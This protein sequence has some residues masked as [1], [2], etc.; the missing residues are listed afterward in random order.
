MRLLRT[1]IYL[2]LTAAV[3]LTFGVGL[4]FLPQTFMEALAIAMSEQAHMFLRFL[5]ASLI[6]HAYLNWQVR[7]AE[8]RIVGPVLI[9]NIIALILAVGIGV[10]TAL[11][12]NI[13]NV[14][15]AILLMH[16]VFL[17]GFITVYVQG[18]YK[19]S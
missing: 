4:L 3:L 5:G 16:T 12:G 1:E 17:S 10:T 13:T 9:M 6:G 8:K 15:S 19:F 14:G 7:R 11:S 2:S 18:K